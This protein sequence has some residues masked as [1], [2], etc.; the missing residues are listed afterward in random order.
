MT[1]IATTQSAN[2]NFGCLK[3]YNY[4]KAG[5][6]AQKRLINNSM[7]NKNKPNLSSLDKF[8]LKFFPKSNLAYR[9]SCLMQSKK[10]ITKG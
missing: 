6:E 4:R 5:L 2:L 3:T 7:G 10:Y 1:T 8:I 9:I